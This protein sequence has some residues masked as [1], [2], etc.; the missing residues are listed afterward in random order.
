M[1]STAKLTERQALLVL[2]A[3]APIGPIALGRLRA[4]LGGDPRAILNAVAGDLEGIDGIGPAARR[5]LA[6]W[7]RLFDPEREEAALA[8]LG[9]DYLVATDAAYP[10]L[11]REIADPPTVLYRSGP[12]ACDYP[13]V[14]V[15][16]S[17]RAT[18]YGLGVARRL[19]SELVDAGFC[20]VSGLARGID[21]AAHEGALAAGG[22]TVAVLG[23]GLDIVF[24]PENGGLFRRIAERGAV[25]TEFSIGR[26]G[27]RGTFPRR[28]RIV[29]GMAAAVIVVES[30]VDG[31][32]MIT[33]R[34]A[35]EQG[36]T[37]FAV[38]GRIDQPTSSGC[39]QLIRDG[40]TL[41]TRV[42]DLFTDLAYLDGL[43]PAPIAEKA[44]PITGG[45]ALSPDEAVVL[46]RFS[47]GGAL[48][49]DELAAATGISAGRLSAALMALELRPL[50]A[51][52]LDGTFEQTS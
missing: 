18:H 35:G 38:P 34:L 16:G 4:A 40:A 46:D 29:S 25:L 21:T 50:I 42:E 39:H 27:D 19:G 45:A 31:G 15:V 28:N 6:G 5:A 17:R 2:N 52:R 8:R 7:R 1:P 49:A 23:T 47:G 9:G 11:L 30:D 44:A 51:R 13:C 33:A 26:Q 43:R 37:V 20:V 36:R 14:A 32:A 48:T 41:F 3:L 12:Y 24:P 10:E 22:P